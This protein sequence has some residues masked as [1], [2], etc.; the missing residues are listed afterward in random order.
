MSKIEDA[1]A[2]YLAGMKY[3]DI[4]KKYGVALSTVKSWKTR[5]KWQRNATKKKSMHTKQKSMRTKRERL[6][7]HCHI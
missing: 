4:A 6:H 3:K 7:H 2:D 5:N 1:K